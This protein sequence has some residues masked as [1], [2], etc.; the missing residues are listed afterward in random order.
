MSALVERRQNE[1]DE[2][3]RTREELRKKGYELHHVASAFGYFK[4]GQVELNAY[5]GKFGS[6]YKI[7][8]HRSGM[9]GT[10]HCVEYW[11]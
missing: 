1:A 11:T 10:H 7:E 6:G 5:K 9:G 3:K 4:L 8:Y 2:I